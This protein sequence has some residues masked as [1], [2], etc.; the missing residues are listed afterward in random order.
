MAKFTV[1][2]HEVHHTAVEVDVPDGAD[3]DAICRAAEIG[4]ANADE[5]KM[6]YS[7]DLPKDNWT[8]RNEAG[9]YLNA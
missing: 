8:V 5:L 4:R 6:E 3:Y 1:E 9:D 7:H 2:I